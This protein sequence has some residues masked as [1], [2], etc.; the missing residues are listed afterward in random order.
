MGAAIPPDAIAPAA[1]AGSRPS[2]LWGRLRGA[3]LLALGAVSLAGASPYLPQSDG[4][5]LARLAPGTSHASVPLRREATSRL[6]VGLAL[7]QFYLARGRSSGDLR[8]L[9]YA[10]AVLAPWRAGATPDP[11]VLVLEA[12]ILQS[13]HDFEASLNEL[14]RALQARP[15]DAQAWLTRATVLR[16]LGRYAEARASCDRLTEV[17]DSLV[18]ELCTESLSALEG[19][20][21]SAYRALRELPQEELSPATR[22]WRYS[23]LGEM[24]QRRGDDHAAEHWYAQGLRVAPDDLYTRA[25]Y[26]DLLLQEQRAAEALTLLYGYESIE[27]LLLRIALAQRQL[28]DPQLSTTRAQLEAAF[29]VEEERGEAVHRREQ[30]RFLLDIAG[31]PAAA[32]RAAEQNWSVQHEPADLLVLLKAAQAAQRPHAAAP[33]VAFIRQHRT[34]D[35]RL[36]PYLARLASRP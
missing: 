34:E 4:E 7:A 25:A 1:R 31:D 15:G 17:A 10:E 11:S 27:P 23:E 33:A 24:A 2:I 29:A 26:A 13:R 35:V 14:D 32:L 21:E 18:G 3:V 5:I 22:A 9:G 6:D 16:V 19:H 36:A 20:L 30:A 8:F 28:H 12:T